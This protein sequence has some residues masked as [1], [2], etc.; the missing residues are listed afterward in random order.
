MMD[1]TKRRAI[2]DLLEK[3]QSDDKQVR[4]DQGQDNHEMQVNSGD[5]QSGTFQNQKVEQELKDPI[6]DVS[7]E[8]QNPNGEGK[9]KPSA[10]NEVIDDQL[11][12][13]TKSQMIPETRQS[14]RLQ[15]HIME[16]VMQASSR[17]RNLEGTN[18]SNTNSFVVLENHEIANLANNM[19]VVINENEFDKIDFMKDLEIAKHNLDNKI[20]N[21]KGLEIS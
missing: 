8:G 7:V 15:N 4:K 10:D 3:V 1:H 11:Q 9:E 5:S 21:A 19:G 20:K 17:K 16:Q 6:K 18:L 14:E 2:P 12:G 13:I